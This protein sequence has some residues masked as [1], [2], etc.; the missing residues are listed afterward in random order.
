[1]NKL[2]SRL[3]VAG[4]AV[5]AIGASAPVAFAE[6]ES[7]QAA[8]ACQQ[9]VLE[10]VV[11]AAD[12]D[13]TGVSFNFDDK[14][15]EQDVAY[16]PAGEEPT[17]DGSGDPVQVAGNAWIRVSVHCYDWLNDSYDGPRR[18]AGEGPVEEVVHAGTFEGATTWF[19]GVDEKREMTETAVDSSVVVN[20]DA[21]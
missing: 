18:I 16:L 10:N 15:A 14:V 3:L 1:M 9:V 13:G 8:P 6:A 4:V 19:I 12:H 17:Q 2:S 11:V 21:R 20:V 7:E 5:A